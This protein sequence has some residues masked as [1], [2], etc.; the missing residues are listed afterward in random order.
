MY[1]QTFCKHCESKQPISMQVF[2]AK[3]NIRFVAVT[4]TRCGHVVNMENWVKLTASE[5]P[6]RTGL[7]TLVVYAVLTLTPKCLMN[8]V[9]RIFA[10]LGYVAATHFEQAAEVPQVVDSFAKQ[11][12]DASGLAPV[13]GEHFTA[14]VSRAFLAM[15]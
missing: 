12:Q 8:R 14:Y 3:N 7:F 11:I 2:Q 10:K 1:A 4:C 5:T 9:G 6:N 13:K 15:S